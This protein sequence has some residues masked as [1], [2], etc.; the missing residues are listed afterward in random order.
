MK[1]AAAIVASEGL[2]ALSMSAIARALDSAVS[3][4]YRYFDG[5]EA[6]YV[7][8][9]TKAIAT[10]AE[11]FS[12]AEKRISA[13][14]ESG[15]TSSKR[16]Q[17]LV[18]VIAV[19]RMYLKMVDSHPVEQAVI[20]A[21][22]SVPAVTLTDDNAARMNEELQSVFAVCIDSLDKAVDA[23][24]ISAGDNRQRTQVF[25]AGLHG[26]QQF[27]KRDRILPKALRVQSMESILIHSLLVGFGANPTEVESAFEY[28]TKEKI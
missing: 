20:D 2:S 13:R 21:F 7:Q 12:L 3:G 28:L 17:A 4:L 5:L 15:S 9:Q 6:V 1:V 25:W 24:S 18:R 27:R 19:F 26:L 8:L 10:Y 22:I 11:Q 14:L 23:K 16:V